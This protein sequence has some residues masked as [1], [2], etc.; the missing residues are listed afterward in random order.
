M[1]L[2]TVVFRF[3][4]NPSLNN[5]EITEVLPQVTLGEVVRWPVGSTFVG[6]ALNP[7]T[8]SE[9]RLFFRKDGEKG[10]SRLSQFVETLLYK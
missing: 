9:T 5:L 8:L 3:M 1:G 7:P 4:G 2:F 10:K 6:V